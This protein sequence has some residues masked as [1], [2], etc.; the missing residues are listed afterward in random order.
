MQDKVTET[1]AKTGENVVLRRYARF[2]TDGTLG[3]YIHHN[4][5]V[6]VIERWRRISGLRLPSLR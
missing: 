3:T 4:G 1:S 2:T 5:R 6:A